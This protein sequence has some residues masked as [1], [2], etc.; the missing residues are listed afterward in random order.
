MNLYLLEPNDI[1][2]WPEY[3]CVLGFVVRAESEIDARQLASKDGCMEDENVFFYS[4]L[5]DDEQKQVEKPKSVW[6]DAQKTKCILLADCVLGDVSI[7]LRSFR[8][9]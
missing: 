9:G 5:D 2:T 4:L 7:V 6:E 1:E 3:D 8:A